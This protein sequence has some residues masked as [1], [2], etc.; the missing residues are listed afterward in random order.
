MLLHA[1]ISGILAA[2]QK[3]TYD[4]VVHTTLESRI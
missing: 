4:F 3:L 2:T 1:Q